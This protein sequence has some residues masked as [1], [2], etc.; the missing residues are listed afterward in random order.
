MT[1]T[2]RRLERLE[3]L[4]GL[5]LTGEPTT[6]AELAEALDV[7]ARTTMRDLDLLRDSGVLIETDRGRGGGLRIASG[8]GGGRVTIRFDEALD[9]LIAMAVSEKLGT[10]AA[11]ER[12]GA[13][14]QKL[15][16]LFAPAYREEMRMLRR[17]IWV[18]AAASP[19]IAAEF[20]L[21]AARH[22][23]VL[24]QAF[25]DRRCLH[26]TYKDRAERE[27]VRV[28]EPQILLLNPPAWYALTWDR[29]REAVRAFRVDRVITAQPMHER[30]KLRQLAPFLAAVES[31]VERL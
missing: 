24:R 13:V 6:V 28:V 17:R 14:R 7:S 11:P 4:R 29:L 27:T 2:V 9:L 16:G 3:R 1:N 8:H 20:D 15:T 21:T 10:P 25:I 19:R 12:L 22:N 18:G 5:L 26:L 30:F 23:A 31:G